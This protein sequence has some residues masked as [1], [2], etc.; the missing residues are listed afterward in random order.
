MMAALLKLLLI[1]N[2]YIFLDSLSRPIVIPS[3]S[4]RTQRKV[5]EQFMCFQKVGDCE[6][7]C[8]NTEQLKYQL[9]RK[10]E[11]KELS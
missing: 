5:S 4:Y 1:V 10:A 3:A 11:L 7:N 9:Q 2:P 8:K 6:T